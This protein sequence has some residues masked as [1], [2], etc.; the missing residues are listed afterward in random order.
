MARD[1]D[2][3]A[4][5]F[6][7][8][9]RRFTHGLETQRQRII[10][11]AANAPKLFEGSDFEVT[12]HGANPG[13]DLDYYIYE[14]GRIR[15]AGISIIKVFRRPDELVAAQ[16]AF[17]A[18]IPKLKDIRDPLTHVND[19]DELDEVAWFSNVVNL[20]PGGRVEGLVDPRH[21]HHDY[22]MAYS[23][24]L[25]T[26]LSKHIQAAIAARDAPEPPPSSTP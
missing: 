15:A 4:S 23:A 7:N 12:N 17:E 21:Q 1:Y 6:L 3:A 10:D 16:A 25:M 19:N 5:R 20:K 11:R 2:K 9:L 8:A 22:A 24:A 13:T 14:L 18:G 26:Y